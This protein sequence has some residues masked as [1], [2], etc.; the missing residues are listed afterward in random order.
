VVK[1]I[2]PD[3]LQKDPEMYVG[4]VAGAS[5]LNEY[6]EFI[7]EAGFDNLKGHKQKKI[8]LP[9]SLISE[10]S[11][12]AETDMPGKEPAGI[13]SITVSAEKKI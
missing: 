7:E 10:F 2:L 11:D 12:H 4:C 5:G 3:L 1:G 9:D 13:F 6:L 8:E